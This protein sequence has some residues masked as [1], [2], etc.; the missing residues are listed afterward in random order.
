MIG[1][2]ATVTNLPSTGTTWRVQ[3]RRGETG[4]ITNH[5]DNRMGAP[6]KLPEHFNQ[7]DWEVTFDDGEKFWFKES[8]LTIEAASGESE[9]G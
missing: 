2:K 9:A 7:Y 8:E 4:V 3:F 6:Y 5:V 1:A